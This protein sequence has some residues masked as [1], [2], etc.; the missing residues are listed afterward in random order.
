MNV[1]FNKPSLDVK[2]RWNSIYTMAEKVLIM[3]EPINTLF[4][5]YN[6]VLVLSEY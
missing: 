2:I 4:E 3:I 6:K 1:P 5:L